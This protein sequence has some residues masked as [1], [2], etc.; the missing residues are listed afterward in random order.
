MIY[1]DRT[2]TSLQATAASRRL[3]GCR[4]ETLAR[5]AATIESRKRADPK[6]S[7]VASLLAGGDDA[8]LKKIGEEATETVLA[9]KDGDRSRTDARGR[10]PVVPLPGAAARH[11]LSPDDVLAELARRARDVGARRKKARDARI[12]GGAPPPRAARPTLIA[13]SLASAGRRRA[14]RYNGGCPFPTRTAFSAR[15]C[16]ARFPAARLTRTT[17]CWRSTTSSRSRPCICC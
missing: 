4:D 14:A 17:T 7:Y 9:A 12:V 3:R 16:A 8:I 5:V 13:S 15:S 2:S 11:G 10:R 1:G 6:A